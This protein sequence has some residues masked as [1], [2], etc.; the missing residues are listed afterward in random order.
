MVCGTS[1]STDCRRG[2]TRNRQGAQGCGGEGQGSNRAERQR[3]SNDLTSRTRCLLSTS[4]DRGYRGDCQHQPCVMTAT[5]ARDNHEQRNS[6]PRP[7]PERMVSRYRVCLLW[8]CPHTSFQQSPNSLGQDEALP[9]TAPNALPVAT[10]QG[11]SD[12][13]LLH[14]LQR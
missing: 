5:V 11:Y 14:R 12:K 10:G 1:G 7:M 13:I 2:K 9:P 8:H 3:C 4:L 6:E